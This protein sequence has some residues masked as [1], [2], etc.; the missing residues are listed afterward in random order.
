MPATTIK[1]DADLYEKAD[2]LRNGTQSISGFVRDLIEKEFRE[3]KMRQATRDYREF[4]ERNPGEMAVMET[5][6]SA[7]LAGEIEPRK[8]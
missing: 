2:S 8:P 4:L 6:E 1:L 3:R 5:W 7:P